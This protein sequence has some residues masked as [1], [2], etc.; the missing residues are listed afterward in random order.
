MSRVLLQGNAESGS[1]QPELLPLDTKTNGSANQ[2]SRNR[3]V[4]P[5]LDRTFTRPGEAGKGPHVHSDAADQLSDSGNDT[6]F[7]QTADSKAN[8]AINR[9]RCQCHKTC[10][11][12]SGRTPR[13][14]AATQ[15]CR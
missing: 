6:T 13:G 9:C 1:S 7:A 11:V 14:Q 15:A 12:P 8:L 4:E 3:Q 10:H 2:V 5:I